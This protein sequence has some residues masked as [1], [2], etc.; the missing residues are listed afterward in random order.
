MDKFSIKIDGVPLLPNINGDII[1]IIVDTDAFQPGMFTIL[2]NDTPTI[3]GQPI[4]T[5]TDN[6]LLF[7][8]GAKVTISA[9]VKVEP[10]PIPSTMELI[11]GEITAIEPLF[12]EDGQVQLRIRGYDAAHRLTLG[13]KT[14][15]WGNG[16]SPTVTEM[17][18]VTTIAGDNGLTPMI[19][20]IGVAS[21]LYEYV[22]QYNQSDW[23]FLWARARI[24]G[25]QLYVTGS[26]LRFTQASIP[27]NLKPVSLIWGENLQNFKPRFVSAGATTGVEAHGY[28]SSLKK[29]ISSKSIPGSANLDPTTSPTVAKGILG[30]AAIATGFRSKAVDH[31]VSPAIT[32]PAT[33]TV[34]AKAHF[35][36]HESHYVRASG[37]CFGDPNLVAGCNTLITNIG[38]R[39]A[40]TYYVT[41]A[42]HI[43]RAGVYKVEFE[44]SGRNPFTFGHLTGQD[45]ELNKINGAVVGIV[46]DINDPLFEGRLKVKYPWMPKGTAGE[47]SSG[48]ARMASLGGGKNGGVYFTPEIDDEVLVIFEQGDVNF[49]YIVGVLWN[50]KDKPPKAASGSPVLAGK[51]N[52]R[53]IKS[54]SGH[55]VVLDDTPGQEKIIILDKSDNGI[56][57]DSVKNSLT[58]KTKGDLVLDV[59]GKFIMNSKLDMTME[60]KTQG[61]IKVSTKL[62]I[63]TQTGATIKAGI[64]QLELTSASAALKSTNV[65]IQ[66]QAKAS[67]K[68]SAMV[69]IQGGLVKIN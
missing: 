27:R 20:P 49:P 9:Y 29:D 16:L 23:D 55:I 52:Q 56:E 58:I 19:D 65:D 54:K 50:K 37:D 2:L 43:F 68:G 10:N 51:V 40:G 44:V 12:L 11:S 14:R 64:S 1:E 36:E 31:I 47:M 24:F 38:T 4:L 63:E 28:S 39:F 41:Q 34:Y 45:P 48:W 22:I 21:L 8:I 7:R 5:H 32:N 35:L 6:L 42:R 57:I 66:G 3:A 17:Q 67:V 60:S 69:E 46:T 33:A 26:M 13:K 15:A 30:G 53:I 25:Y 18:I 59:G 62:D 61:S